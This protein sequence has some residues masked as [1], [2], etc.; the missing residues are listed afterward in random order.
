[1]PALDKES[2]TF[3]ISNFYTVYGM[4]GI[5]Y[6]V[7]FGHLF[8][9]ALSVSTTL[10]LMGCT[11]FISNLG[12][13]SNEYKPGTLLNTIPAVI[14]SKANNVQKKFCQLQKNAVT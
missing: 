9:P 1:M 11:K 3:V 6:F 5:E 14:N 4:D 10:S 12:Y 2:K 13:H 8:C 7:T